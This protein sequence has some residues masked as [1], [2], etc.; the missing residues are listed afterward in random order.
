MKMHGT[1]V[2]GGGRFFL[3]FDCREFQY[4]LYREI[5]T[6]R[7]STAVRMET[8]EGLHFIFTFV[9]LLSS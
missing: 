1:Y 4:Q 3:N 6:V 9:K 2:G 5:R 7:G 8:V